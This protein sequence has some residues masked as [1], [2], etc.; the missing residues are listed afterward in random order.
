MANSSWFVFAS[1]GAPAA[2]RRSTEVAVYGGR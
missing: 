1:S 2:T